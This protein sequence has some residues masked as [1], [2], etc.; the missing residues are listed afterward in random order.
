MRARRDA[1]VRSDVPPAGVRRG[2]ARRPRG[3][4]VQR[5]HASRRDP[6]GL[7]RFRGSGQRHCRPVRPTEG[8]IMIALKK[9][10]CPIDFS[11]HSRVALDYATALA[12]WY[13]AEIRA[14]HAY[15][16]AMVPATI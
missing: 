11:G 9:I 14:L 15:S 10:L 16:V 6:H 5:R 1:A 8:G 2:V 4:R 13:E 12:Q 7:S 3:D